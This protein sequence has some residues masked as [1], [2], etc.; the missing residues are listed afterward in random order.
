MPRTTSKPKNCQSC[1]K[2]LPVPRGNTTK[3]HKD[4]RPYRAGQFKPKQ[5]PTCG[6]DLPIPR[7]NRQVYCKGNCKR[8]ADNERSRIC[9]YNR[10]KRKN[11][12]KCGVSLFDSLRHRIFCKTCASKPV[13]PRLTN[14]TICGVDMATESYRGTKY[15]PKCASGAH[16]KATIDRNNTRHKEEPEKHC[17]TVKASNLK[18]RMEAIHALGDKCELEDKTCKGSLQFHH[19]NF[20][21]HL[22]PTRRGGP[23]VARDVLRQADPKIK[24]Q[25]LC[26]S[27]HKRVD[28]KHRKEEYD[29]ASIH[30]SPFT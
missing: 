7:N 15:C 11:C 13:Y 6:K 8:L 26:N 19:R 29:K 3:Y 24:Y 16:Y 27:H 21:G 2:A 5:C 30:D 17:E 10:R 1:G 9:H 12:V 25:L 22:D 14:C 23:D 20:D 18:R 4:C 28:A